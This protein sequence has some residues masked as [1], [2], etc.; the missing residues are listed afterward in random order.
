MTAK[1]ENVMTEIGIE[2]FGA[3]FTD[4]GSVTVK[5]FSIYSSKYSHIAVY[6][7]AAHTMHL[8][9]GDINNRNLLRTQLT[10]AHASLKKSTSRKLNTEI[11]LCRAPE[12]ERKDLLSKNS[13]AQ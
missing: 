2:K 8:I 12:N 11:L 6:T 7:W 4:N 5:I 9:I 1:M 13:G 10:L 3:A